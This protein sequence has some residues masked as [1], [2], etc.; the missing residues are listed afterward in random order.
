MKKAILVFLIIVNSNLYIHAQ[1]LI[2]KW[3]DKIE[4]H[5][6]KDGFF[7]SF[8]GENK[9]Y[10]YAYFNKDVIDKNDE[11][12]KIVAFDKKTMK[13]RFVAEV[14]GYP[15]NSKELK[16]Y[17]GL[18]HYKTIIY[19]D[20]IYAF[21]LSGDKNSNFLLVKSF[22]PELKVMDAMKVITSQPK[23]RQIKNK[24]ANIFVLGNKKIAKVFIGIEK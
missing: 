5:N 23:I 24:P 6:S 2:N 7:S 8:I 19:E 4:L 1:N 3:S 15:S 10:L 16:K 11:S 12:K 9:N 13:R 22:S 21:F 18:I 20:V 14:I 17:K